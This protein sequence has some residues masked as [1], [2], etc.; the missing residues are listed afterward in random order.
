[1][2]R[3]GSMPK[4]SVVIAAYNRARFLAECIESVLSQSF[5]D[6]EVVIVDDGSTDNT[7]EVVSRYLPPAKYFYQENQGAPATYSKG[8][9]LARGDYIALLGSDDALLEDALQKGVEVLDRWPNVGFSYGQA[10]IMDEEGH[11][12]E[13]SRPRHRKGSYVR[14]GREEIK[15][16]ILGNYITGSTTMIRRSCFAE[17]GLFNPVFYRGSED[18][19]MWVRLAK[20]YDVAYID[21]PLAKYRVH[22]QSLSAGR[23]VDEVK[24]AHGLIL[25]SIFDDGELG[26]Q[27][28]K[29]RAQ[30][31]YHF[32]CRLARIARA[33]GEFKTGRSYLLK[34]LR[35][36]PKSMFQMDA[37]NWQFLWA[38][39][40]LPNTLVDFSRR[41]GN[42][43]ILL[44]K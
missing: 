38:K 23:Q 15:D 21:S 39:A 20:R 19:D 43:M 27:Y 32:Y 14:S 42:R 41:V 9:E 40:V 13:L 30:A 5:H 29:L 24:L 26:H 3:R 33:R 16:L 31:N 22:R 44:K 11:I 34:A 12:T 10:Y 8:I 35:V 37:A 1:M 4:V 7:R 17:V 25:E 36:Y 2:L 18:F 28:D 6:F